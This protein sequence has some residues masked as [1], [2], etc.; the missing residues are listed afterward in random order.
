MNG[1]TPLRHY[2]NR[3]P[4]SCKC[5]EKAKPIHERNWTVTLWLPYK[6]W[7]PK[8]YHYI[9]RLMLDFT[10]LSCSAHW[11]N[12]NINSPVWKLININ[13]KDIQHQSK[14]IH[15]NTIKKDEQLIP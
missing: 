2:K 6:V 14:C 13:P 3:E 12:K 1:M 7:G 11:R 15:L 8:A 4:G 9:E 10:C 5:E